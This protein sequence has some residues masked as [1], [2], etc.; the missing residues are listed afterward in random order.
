MKNVQLFSLIPFFVFLGC[1]T[2]DDQKKGTS[3]LVVIPTLG[4]TSPTSYPGMNLVWSDEFDGNT[5]NSA[6]WAHET[7]NGQNGCGNN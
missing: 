1:V 4:A 5:L 3:D 6:N 7:G 2:E